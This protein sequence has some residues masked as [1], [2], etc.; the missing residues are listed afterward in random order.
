M[1]RSLHCPHC[2][3]DFDYDLVPGMSVTAVRLG[4]SRY[5]RCPLCHRF[6][7][8]RVD[9]V[10]AEASQPP[11]GN[12]PAIA[13]TVL[14]GPDTPSSVR[15]RF[16][17][18]RPLARWAGVLVVPIVALLVLAL[19]VPLSTRAEWAVL[20]ACGAFVVLAV[21]LMI[22]FLLPDRVR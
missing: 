13:P 7:T 4:R 3:R 9:R 16:D 5:M 8:F 12:A 15:P 11:A 14:R 21:A 2:D 6:A 18:R 1:T 19:V 10:S 17:D 22:A 20:I